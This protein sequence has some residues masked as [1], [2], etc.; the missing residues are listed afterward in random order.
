MNKTSAK[1]FLLGAAV[2]MATGGAC[3]QVKETPEHRA[4]A[5]RYV[6]PVCVIA[7]K[8]EKGKCRF[9]L[10]CRFS[11][12]Y[13]MMDYKLEPP[14][15]FTFDGK[16][17]DEKLA[18]SAAC[19]YKTSAF[20]L[21]DASGNVRRDEHDFR[22]IK[23]AETKINADRTSDLAIQLKDAAYPAETELRIVFEGRD[24]KTQKLDVFRVPTKAANSENLP[25]YDW[26]NLILKNPR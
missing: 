3:Y 12:G 2:W 9:D 17:F 24:G 7:E 25:E 20:V 11:T 23:F 5:A 18:L 26:E 6:L 1:I 13:L 16:P 21:T 8:I 15:T 22:K 4:N 10:D 19:E 14:A